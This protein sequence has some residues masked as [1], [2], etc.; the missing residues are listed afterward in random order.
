MRNREVAKIFY[1]I[2]DILELQNVK[3][4][5]Q[6]YRKA[7]HSIESLEED[8]ET[9]KD[10]KAIPGIGDALA[11]KISEILKTGRLQYLERLRREIPEGADQL[12]Q[13]PEIGPKTAQFLAS[14]GITS[15]E[16]LEKVL[17]RH[18][19]QKMKGFGPK[20]EGNLKRAIQLYKFSKERRLL[21]KVI[22][23]CRE[24]E[25]ALKDF[26]DTVVVSGS[27]RRWKETV[28]DIDVL[29]VS[30]TPEVTI[31]TF[32]RLPFVEQVLEKGSTKSTVIVEGMQ[33]DLRVVPR[34]SFGSALQYFTGSKEHNISL[35][36]RALKKG[37]KLNEYGLF[38]VETGLKVA[39][40]SEEALYNNLG[41]VY[42]PP[43]LRE[44][45]GEIQAALNNR[46]PDL[47]NITQVKGD[48]HVHTDWSDG[49]DS[50]KTMAVKASELHYEYIGICD[51]SQSSKIARGLSQER[52][53]DQN[54]Y[55]KEL[56]DCTPEIEIL[57]GVE[58]DI[59]PDGSLDYPDSVLEQL[60][61]VVASIHSRF[62]SSTEET[63]QRIVRALENPLVTILGH[64]T[65]RIIG[66]RDP[67]NLDLGKVIETAR[68]MKTALEINCYPDRLDLK[69]SHVREAKSRGVVCALG[70][71]AHS[72]R[73][74]NYMELGVGTARRGW[75]EP[76]NVLNTLGYHDLVQLWK[77]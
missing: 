70:T 45:Q 77:Q 58:C 48:F 25:K 24:I 39:G 44:D 47:I 33:T 52:L 65:G 60:D 29:A 14:Q 12:M 64:P 11:K 15:I 50:V 73:D 69:D 6:A 67:L 43:E 23:L 74:L 2:A 17:E 75:A 59:L 61:L 28:G 21:G 62:K 20:M 36:K 46:L 31:E 37:F 49:K 16:D 66:R 57:S 40:E 38:D 32:I 30:S 3:F 72:V 35:R 22:P 27:V 71:D 42:I 56:N 10:L 13:L 63:T 53:L 54:A 7:A 26:S 51:H 8:I 41:L 68:E 34:E 5:P 18:S 4:K 1:E 55:I 76:E 9:V 19:L